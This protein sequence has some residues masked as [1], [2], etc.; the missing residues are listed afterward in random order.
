MNL[1]SF[2]QNI[3]TVSN[4]GVKKEKMRMEPVDMTAK[5]VDK[6]IVFYELR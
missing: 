3:K 1:I 4:V 6:I 5:N 2:V